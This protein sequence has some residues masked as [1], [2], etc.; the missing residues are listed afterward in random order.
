[1]G[2]VVVVVGVGGMGL[3]CARR[4]GAGQRLLLADF[5]ASAL[6][7]AASVLTNSGYDVRTIVVDVAHPWSVENLA[8]LASSM[9]EL[10]ALVHTAG[11][12]P[13]M[14]EPARIF[15]VD[16]VGTALV[17]DA[18]LPLARPG[19]V[20]VVIASMAPQLVATPVELERSLA[21][22]RTDE[23]LDVIGEL[24]KDDPYGA[25]AVSKRGN[26]LRVEAAVSAWGERGA[27]IV[28][29][30][31]GLIHTGM[32]V[33]EENASDQVVALREATPMGRVGT[34]EDIAA[35]VD[36]LIGPAASFITGIDLR[37]DGG[38]VSAVRYVSTD[39]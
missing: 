18:F 28:S 5:D 25:Y 10:R 7:S 15:A 23:L 14:A 16:L 20:A 21:T 6:E 33:K 24:H 39:C 1:M 38:V 8:S 9:G 31:P 29:I 32:G 26:Q 2:N 11:L 34:P 36:W 37:I 35:A 13:T 3:A 12:S 30:S 17:I 4:I 27:R 19:S 22:A